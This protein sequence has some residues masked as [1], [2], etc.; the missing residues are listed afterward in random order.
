[1]LRR[2][3]ECSTR[4]ELGVTL[5]GYMPLAAGALTG[6]YRQPLAGR[7]AAVHEPFPGKNLAVLSDLLDLLREIGGRSRHGPNQVALRWLMQQEQC[8]YRRRQERRSGEP[9]RSS[10]TF[11]LDDDELDAIDRATAPDSKRRR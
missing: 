6:K 10:V 7:M 4:A 1:M 5:I 9:E 8:F 2:P 11:S 3:T